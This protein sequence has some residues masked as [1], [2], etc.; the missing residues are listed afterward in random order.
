MR[1]T[2]LVPAPPGPA[3]LPLTHA[4]A[5][6]GGCASRDAGALEQLVPVLL[7][8]QAACQQVV[9]V[10]G[11]QL[12]PA[13]R[14]RETLEVEHLVT[15]VL[16][17]LLLG[18]TSRGAP[19]TWPVTGPHH[20]LARGDCLSTGRT[21]PRDSEHP[22]TTQVRYT[23]IE[24]RMQWHVAAPLGSDFKSFFSSLNIVPGTYIFPHG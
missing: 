11:H 8:D 14:T 24:L 7:A 13:F 5:C 2:C 21:R 22:E 10:A 3:H 6:A 1:L 23:Q 19:L 16:L 18:P 12:C 15:A 4:G 20:E 9:A 17:C